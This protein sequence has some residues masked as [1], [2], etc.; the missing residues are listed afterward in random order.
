VI[1][2]AFVGGHVP[3]MDDLN[4]TWNT[5]L[6]HYFSKLFKDN[7]ILPNNLLERM[8]EIVQKDIDS[9]LVKNCNREDDYM[10]IMQTMYLYG[11]YK[12]NDDTNFMDRIEV[13]NSNNDEG[14]FMKN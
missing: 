2:S 5:S 10:A 12:L 13:D 11:H 6:Q 4:K 9:M 1:L 8:K 3:S 7:R 14:K